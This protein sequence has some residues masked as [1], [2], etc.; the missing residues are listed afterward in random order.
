MVEASENRVAGFIRNASIVLIGLLGVGLL[1]R[2]VLV[3]NYDYDELSHAHLAWLVSIGEV[4]YRDFAANHFPFLWIL[5]S[6]LM[7]VL[8]ANPAALVVLRGLALT[9]NLV[10]IAALVTLICAE[11][12]P[13]ERIWAIA[14]FGLVVF[15]PLTMHFLIEFRPDAIAN[16]LLF[17]ILACLRL[18]GLGGIPTAALSGLGIGA[19][20][21]INT[22]YEL[23]PF[24][25]GIVALVIY[26]RQLKQIWPL[27]LALALG[28][29]MAVLGGML[30]MKGIGV[31][32]DDAWRM[33]VT[34][35]AM[36]EKTHA[37]GFGLAHT[38][39]NSPAWLA[40]D[41]VGLIGCVALFRRQ[42]RSPE[43]FISAIFIFLM[44]SLFTT[45]RPWKQYAV[46]WLLL[47]A[48]LPARTLPLLITRLRPRMQVVVAFCVLMVIAV[49]LART[50]RVDPN[51]GGIDR[52][53]QD[54]A[55]QWILRHVPAD[56]FVVASLDLH[57]VFR[58]D[59]FFKVVADQMAD[60]RDGLEQFMPYLV[61]PS[62]AGC[63]QESGCEQEL[64]THPPAL[65]VTQGKYTSAQVQAMNTWLAS[66]TNIYVQST[67]PGTPVVV[68]ERSAYHPASGGK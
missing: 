54:A 44:I 62:R 63:F 1:V 6:P 27:A 61:G 43:L 7:R 24:V 5:L 35:N 59:T 29:V 55:I 51:G 68:L 49:G 37:F 40:F 15:T 32:L 50:G 52:Q 56:D 22:K 11:L 19:A 47:A 64:E 12:H 9:L 25:L 36:V 3:R 31:S 60:G 67:I 34:Y 4:P 65:F 39:I 23:F 10:F 21:L 2:L 58:R 38:L 33:V 14:C 26:V 18:R 17:S 45:T 53:T 28:F 16:A 8:P 48:A 20:L 42:R 46:S 30:V 13:R 41:L 57:P 66:P